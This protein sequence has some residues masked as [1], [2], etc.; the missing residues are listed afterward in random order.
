MQVSRI[1]LD[2]PLLVAPR[3]FEDER[4]F[5]FESYSLD[6]YAA[7]GIDAVFVQDNH[8]RSGAR[9]LR[10]LHYQARP[11]Q[12]KLVRVT[13]GRIWDVVVD[14]RP[15][16]P[17]YGEWEG[18]V[19]DASAHHQLFIPIGFAHGFCVLGD[20][21][22]VTYKVSSVYDAAEE[23]TIAYNDPDLA[24]RWPLRQPVVSARDASGESFA[25][26]KARMA[27]GATR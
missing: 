18:L 9:T 12:A 22:E 3:V 6:R 2:G 17:T 5:F 11:G 20:H 15:D 14:L 13:S 26:Y 16:S 19:L 10:G 21:A 24:I 1:R 27:A 7:A 25:S 23:K 4:G 8:S